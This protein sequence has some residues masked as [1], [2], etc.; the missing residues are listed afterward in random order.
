MGTQNRL[1]TLK[2]RF[3]VSYEIQYTFTAWPSNLPYRYLSEIELCSYKICLWRLFIA[4]VSASPKT[5]NPG[6]PQLGEGLTHC[7]ACLQYYSA[8]QKEKS[9]KHHRMSESQM[10]YAKMPN[11]NVYP[12]NDS[13][14]ITFCKSKITDAGDRPVVARA[15]GWKC[16]LP[17][18]GNRGISGGV[19]VRPPIPWLWC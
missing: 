15:R 7:G 1:G 6:V 8:T 5:E 2:N 16:G 10:H 17:A 9:K 18:V 19:V 4:A 3:S 11:Y 14:Y 12:Y 13:V